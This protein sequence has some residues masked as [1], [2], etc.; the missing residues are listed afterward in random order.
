MKAFTLIELMLIMGVI[1]VA[2]ALSILG[3]T[4]FRS[5]IELN[6]AYTNVI[7]YLNDIK[8]KSTNAFG[9]TSNGVLLS[10]VDFFGVSFE[11]KDV[12]ALNCNGNFDF[13]NYSCTSSLETGALNLGNITTSI[14]TCG[15]RIG[16]KRLTSDLVSLNTT[17]GLITTGTCELQLQ[18]SFTNETKTITIDLVRNTYR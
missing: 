3:L 4:R 17:G 18:H 14:T 13:S 16:F 8:N 5:A 1:A 10:E 12:T 2:M 15:N 11:G 9:T 7:S 6:T